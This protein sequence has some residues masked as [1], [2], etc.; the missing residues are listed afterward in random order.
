MATT[1]SIPASVSRSKISR[2]RNNKPAAPARP[3]RR[4]K[5]NAAPAETFGEY[6]VTL[7]PGV[8]V[9]ARLPDDGGAECVLVKS[10]KEGVVVRKA[11]SDDTTLRSVLWRDI[12]F[13]VEDAGEV[14]TRE[15]GGNGNGVDLV[16]VLSGATSAA[17]QA[18]FKALA[19]K[20]EDEINAIREAIESKRPTPT[21]APSAPGTVEIRLA[22]GPGFKTKAMIRDA[23]HACTVVAAYKHCLLVRTDSDLG[24]YEGRD[25]RLH[26][27]SWADLLLE[28]PDV[29]DPTFVSG[30]A[31]SD[32][33]PDSIM[34]EIKPGT[35][36]EVYV[37]G[38]SVIATVVSASKAG[39]FVKL[40]EDADGK[41]KGELIGVKWDDFIADA[42]ASMVSTRTD[43]T[44]SPA[45]W[46]IP[47]AVGTKCV[48]WDGSE[49]DS[50][51]AEIV[52]VGE[53]GI[54]ARVIAGENEG[55]IVA[56]KWDCVTFGRA[57]EHD[58]MKEIGYVDSFVP[59]DPP[60]AKQV[61]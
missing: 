1:H 12:A 32:A 11:K 40:D 28:L 18:L 21:L 24:Q 13:R 29:D 35:P 57:L 31:E 42:E 41:R 16:S 43:A 61:A 37:E 39:V 26:S 7:K 58:A 17:R 52:E 59:C 19:G 4:G 56:R 55:S 47:I 6:H 8:R 54:F 51:P 5:A 27:I 36:C 45:A 9:F 14:I 48:V 46:N 15:R 10:N 3:K 38:S 34:L 20:S 33:K 50:D 30:G 49:S 60:G 22:V 53:N 44:T 2:S 23:D 25:G